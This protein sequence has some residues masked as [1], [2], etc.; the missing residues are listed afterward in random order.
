MQMIEKRPGVCKRVCN[1]FMNSEQNGVEK[2]M[3]YYLTKRKKANRSY[4]YVFFTDV[5]EI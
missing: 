5:E 4:W 3:D 2:S 1:G